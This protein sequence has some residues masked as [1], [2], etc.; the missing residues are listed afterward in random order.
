MAI[1]Y[2]LS[3]T[4]R[5]IDEKLGMVDALNQNKLDASALS[6][7]NTSTSSHADIRE[8]INQLSSEKVDRSGMTLGVHTDGFVYLFVNGSPQGNGLDIKADVIE[9]DVFGYVDDNNNI[10]LQGNI[11][12]NGTYTFAYKTKDGTVINIGSAEFVPDSDLP[13]TNLADP[14][15]N[16]WYT[17]TRLSATN[18]EPKDI[19]TTTGHIVTNFIPAKM[20][21]VL[22]VKGLNITSKV[23]TKHFYMCAYQGENKTYQ[24]HS[25]VTTISTASA[26]GALNSVSVDGDVSTYTI[27]MQDDGEQKAPSTTSYVRFSG[28]LL[29]GYTLNDVVI[30]IN[31]EIV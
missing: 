12:E 14:T 8:E 21:D 2:K 10:I 24:G 31:E 15:S 22:R 16:D 9:G 27:L 6:T 3:Y 25:S 18:G 26:D 30:T 7:H 19:G 17:D 20:G 28:S 29:D 1:E 23:G 13:Y 4:G 11:D 5:E